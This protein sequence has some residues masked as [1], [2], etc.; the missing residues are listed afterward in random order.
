VRVAFFGTPDLA[1][2]YLDALVEGGHEV[3][4]AITQPDR[5][6]GRGRDVR[7]G[8]VKVA[9][10][11]RGLRVL[12]PEHCGEAGLA[13][14]LRD[15]DAE[16]GVT[17]AYGEILPP[18][19]LEC[20]GLGCVN[21]H[22]SLLPELRGA[23]PVQHALL[24]GLARTGVT[25]QWMAEELDAGD[26]IAAERVPI[27][28]ED[29]CGSLFA[30]LTAVGP[31]LLLRVVGL[32]GAGQAPRT[33]QDE[34]GVSWAPPLTKTDCLLDWA[35]PAEAVRNRVRALAPRPGAFTLRS[36]KR[37]KVLKAQVAVGPAEAAEGIPGSLAEWTL[38]GC[39]VVCC[40]RHAVALEVVQAEGKHPVAGADYAR[41]ARLE[42]GERLG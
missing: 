14:S 8:P 19:V 22:Y 4:V 24:R 27:D 15:C 7:A 16:L 42:P 9:A 20:P 23:A 11:A 41:G 21:V 38:E 5:P 37:L 2:P 26:V 34:A 25:V 3:C 33:P 29:D 13:A 35:A 39:P 12:Q 32:I 1:V 28:A 30:R 6:A 10:Q 31:S 40:G 18:T 17:V 36:G